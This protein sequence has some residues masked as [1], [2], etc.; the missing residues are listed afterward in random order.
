M[1]R[2][3][4]APLPFGVAAVLL[5]A[6]AYLALARFAAPPV[7][8]LD[9]PWPLVMGIG[10][11]SLYCVRDLLRA[12]DRRARLVSVGAVS[13]AALSLAGL[14][15]ASRGNLPKPSREVAIGSTLPSLG[16]PDETGHVVTL[17][18][19]RGHPTV[20]VFYRGALCVACRAEL[21]AIAEHARPFLAEGVRVFGVSADP[22]SLSLEWKQSLALP[23]SLLTDD[24][25]GLAE[26]L[27]SARA[28]CLLLVDPSGVVR[29]GALNDYWRGAERA[30]SVLLAAYRL[31]AR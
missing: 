14:S 6:P 31:A 10:A 13:C 24:H 12:R 17:S 22:P 5:G 18:S 26:A 8:L 20:L 25:Q 21:M 1:Q 16:L 23:F 27:C 15:W 9:R 3:S 2:A 28:H 7:W 19:L 29:W 11:V 30:D 4:F